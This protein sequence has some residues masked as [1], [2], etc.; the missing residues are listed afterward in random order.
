M[1]SE[2]VFERFETKLVTHKGV[3]F[4]QQYEGF[5]I[6]TP[7]IHRMSIWGEII[8]GVVGH[9]G[10]T[11]EVGRQDEGDG[12]DPAHYSSCLWF[13]FCIGIQCLVL[14]REVP[15]QV[16]VVTVRSAS[17]SLYITCRWKY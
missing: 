14:V 16:H 3:G 8:K 5:V 1:S 11:M 12:L 2:A 10:S 17:D 9:K 13:L 6:W 15:V 4:S 7:A